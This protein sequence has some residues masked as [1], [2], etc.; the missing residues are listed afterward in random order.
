MFQLFKAKEIRSLAKKSVGV[1]VAAKVFNSPIESILGISF[2]LA[3]VIEAQIGAFQRFSSPDKILAFA[4]LSPTTYQSG[5]FTSQNAVM[6]KR[7]S[8]YLRSTFFLAAHLVSIHS[9]TF[10]TERR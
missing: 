9:K 10:A 3:G 1:Y 8:R 7:G 2:R 6:E 5:K 4:G